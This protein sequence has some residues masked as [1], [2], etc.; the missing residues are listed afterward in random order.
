[1]H[2]IYSLEFWPMPF[3]FFL[4]VNGVAMREL[5]AMD[6]PNRIPG[7]WGKNNMGIHGHGIHTYM[8][9]AWPHGTWPHL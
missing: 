7:T 2:D 9:L 3:E 6:M 1:M 4:P 8:N 5:Q